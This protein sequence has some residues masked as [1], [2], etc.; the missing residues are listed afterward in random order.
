MPLINCKVESKLKWTN[1]CVLF[2]AGNDNL[3]KNDNDNDGSNIVFTIRDS[4]L[5]AL[6]VTSS[7]TENQKLLERFSKG[8]ERLLE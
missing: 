7:A 3:N 2:A 5:Y 8:F 4:K 1:Y 6:V